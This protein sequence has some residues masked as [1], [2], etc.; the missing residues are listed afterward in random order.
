MRAGGTP[1]VEDGS[2]WDDNGLPWVS[3]ADM[4]RAP[5]V[6]DTERRVSPAAIK[7]KALP[8][9]AAGTLL[10]AMYASVGAV[11]VLGTEASWNQAI[12]GIAPRRGLADVGF[13][14]YW[15]EHLK[16]DLVA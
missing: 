2:M 4:S 1:A 6:V 15:L 10:F 9:G 14:G 12:L 16:P 7:A 3:I 5:I 13:V 11:G 8:V